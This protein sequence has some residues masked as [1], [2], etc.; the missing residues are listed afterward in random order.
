M[1][2]ISY[3]SNPE[4]RNAPSSAARGRID[5]LNENLDFCNKCYRNRAWE[6]RSDLVPDELLD[7]EWLTLDG[8][9]HPAY[10]EDDPMYKCCGCGVQL[11][12]DDN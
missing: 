6:D 4:F 1:P 5:P 3:P 12:D 2:R 11:T 8:Q 10:G 7:S 9:D